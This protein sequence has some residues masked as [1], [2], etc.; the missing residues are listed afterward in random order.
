MQSAMDF[1]ANMPVE[2]MSFKDMKGILVQAIRDG[3]IDE[4]GQGYVFGFYRAVNA[5]N[6]P[7]ADL[8]AVVRR[9][10]GECKRPMSDDYDFVIDYKD[11]FERSDLIDDTAE[12]YAEF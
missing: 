7:S 6:E 2:K 1:H 11:T 8:M 5:G 4:W 10:V 3:R 9:I 12:N